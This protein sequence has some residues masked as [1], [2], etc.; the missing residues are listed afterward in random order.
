MR[1]VLVLIGLY[2]AFGT[3]LAADPPIEDDL[4][5]S[6]APLSDQVEY[7]SWFKLSFLNLPED[8]E[9]A[10]DAGKKGLIVYFGQHHCAYCKALMV[11]GFGREDIAMYTQRNFDVVALDIWSDRMVTDMQHFILPEKELAVREKT[12]FTPSLIFYDASGREV[13]RLRGY[14]PPYKLLAALEYVADGH[15]R[16]ATFHDYLDRGASAMSFLEGGLNESELFTEGPAILQR[17]PVYGERPLAVFFEQPLCHACDLLHTGPLSD[18][19]I[20]RLLG[21]MDVAQL[22]MSGSGPVVIPTGERLTAQQWARQM[23]LFHAPTVIFFD[24]WGVEILRIDSVVQLYRMRSVLEYVLS[25]D[26][27][28]E[29]NFQRWRELN[30]RAGEEARESAD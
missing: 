3:A 23:G 1:F 8:L 24:E 9:E 14:Y 29:P 27:L 28:F 20:R 25:E 21:R 5:F 26:Y 7:P 22:N 15:Y 18:P 13:L 17:D 2:L 16:G 11:R 30:S 10:V 6:D 12:N 19:E 4:E